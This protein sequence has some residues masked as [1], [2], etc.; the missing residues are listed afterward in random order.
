MNRPRFSLVLPA[1]NAAA[2]ADRAFAEVTAFL[3]DRPQWEAIFVC[4]GCRDGSDLRLQELSDNSPLRI[5]TIRYTRNRG[6]GYAVRLGL[7]QAKGHYRIFTDVDLAYRL[8]QVQT[9]AEQLEAGRDVVIA[10]RAHTESEIVAPGDIQTYLRKRKLQSLVFSTIAKSILGIRQRDPQAGLKGLSARAATTI[11]P[12]VKCPG[13]GFDCELI[14]ACKYF[15]IAIQEVPVTVHYD[16]LES[17]TS[18]K[19]SLSMIRE[20]WAIRKYWAAIRH[21]GLTSSILTSISADNIQALRKRTR[22][23]RRIERKLAAAHP[24]T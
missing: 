1:Y 23:T 18:L 16:N 15:G 8:D 3:A 5:R 14:V 21:R 17:T 9:V 19:S 12:H 6:K 4:D 24:E 10:S 2:V 13:F 7:M 22:R 11:L 20:L